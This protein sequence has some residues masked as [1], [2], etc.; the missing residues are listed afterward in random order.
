MIYFL[1]Y[2]VFF[3]VFRLLARVLGRMHSTGETFVPR[4]GPVIYCP[5]HVSDADPPVVFVCLPRRAWFIAK[6]E[7]F[8]VP[9][10][11]WVLSRFHAF[12]I[13]RDTADRTALRRAEGV[14]RRGEPLVIFPEGRCAQDGKLQRMQPGAALLSV[15]TGA[16]IVPIGLRH[17]NELLPYGA[18]FPRFSRHPV[19]VDFGPP[20]RRADFAH[21]PRGAV[22]DA[23]TRKLGE[24]L[25]RLTQQSPPPAPPPG[26]LKRA[27]QQAE[28]PASEA[29]MTEASAPA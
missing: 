27:K 21:L 1:L 16:P 26:L 25:A 3:S 9:G 24:E 2:P 28:E 22:V 10:F 19:R 17:T 29:S 23:M 4:T 13:K 7:L 15:R 14:L 5:N 20:I 11:G 18:K 8:A 6:S 12:P